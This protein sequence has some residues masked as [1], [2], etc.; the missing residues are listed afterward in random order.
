MTKTGLV[1]RRYE[2]WSRQPLVREYMESSDSS[3][4]QICNGESIGHPWCSQLDMYNSTRLVMVEVALYSEAP[5]S[6]A[7]IGVLAQYV[8]LWGSGVEHNLRRRPSSI[9]SR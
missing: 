4:Y 3:C 8:T 7:I 9:T 1:V 6:C 5:V 2:P